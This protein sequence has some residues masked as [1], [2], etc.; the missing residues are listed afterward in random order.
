MT[1]HMTSHMT[2]NIMQMKTGQ[3]QCLNKIKQVHVKGNVSDFEGKF[4]YP[5]IPFNSLLDLLL[6]MPF[7]N[8]SLNSMF[9]VMPTSVELVT[10]P[11]VSFFSSGSERLMPVSS[12]ILLGKLYN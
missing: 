4:I 11:F 7:Q 6:E 5:V 12:T 10:L 1:S 8:I 3:K 2:S 9:G